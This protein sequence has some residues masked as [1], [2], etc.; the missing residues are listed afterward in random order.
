MRTKRHTSGTEAA[1]T[2]ALFAGS[3]TAAGRVAPSPMGGVRVAAMSEV[4]VSR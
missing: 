3:V 1:Q 4:G 2:R